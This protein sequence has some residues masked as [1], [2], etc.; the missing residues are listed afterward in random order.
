MLVI[1]YFCLCMC[2]YVT[3]TQNKKYTKGHTQKSATFGILGDTPTPLP[4]ED[5]PLQTS[6]LL[7]LLMVAQHDLILRHTTE[8]RYTLYW[9]C[10]NHAGTD[11]EAC[12]LLACFHCTLKV[13]CR[14]VFINIFTQLWTL[15]ATIMAWMLEGQPVTIWLNLRPTPQVET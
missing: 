2:D 5:P 9:T 3:Y 6:T 7:P 12:F 4:S 15:W 8:E 13:L 1:M 14:M 11:L 10:R